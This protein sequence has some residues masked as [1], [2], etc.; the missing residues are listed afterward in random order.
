MRYRVA[1][2]TS[3]FNEEI[4]QALYTGA[5]ACLEAE[6][7]K[8]KSID[9]YWV[10]GAVEIPMLAAR[11]FRQ[12]DYHGILALGAVIFGETDHYDYVCQ[13]V[14]YGCQ[15]VA[16]ESQKPLA[17]GILTCKTMQQAKDRIGGR[18]GHK[19]VEA[20]TALL[21]TISTIQSLQSPNT[22]NE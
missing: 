11:L 9:T 20:A 12:Y 13:Q 16:I 18:C 3:R 14:S 1:I 2:I 4:T 10:P 8:I 19:G 15:K 5:L 17:F 6:K 7:E 22:A 21:E